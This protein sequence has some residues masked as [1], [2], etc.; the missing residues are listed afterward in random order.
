MNGWV[1][2]AK[3]CFLVAGMGVCDKDTEIYKISPE[4]IMK[5]RRECE[6]VQDTGQFIDDI[7]KYKILKKNEFDYVFVQ[8][9]RY[10]G[11]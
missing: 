2:I 5:S 10:I 7:V 1:L 9:R 11:S 4:G 6:A 3:F 8:C